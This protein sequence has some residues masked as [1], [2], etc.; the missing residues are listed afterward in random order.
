[1]IRYIFSFPTF[2][3]LASDYE[4]DFISCKTNFNHERKGVF[5]IKPKELDKWIPLECNDGTSDNNNFRFINSRALKTIDLVGEGTRLIDMDTYSIEGKS[6]QFSVLCEYYQTIRLDYFENK[7]VDFEGQIVNVSFSMGI[8]IPQGELDNIHSF[9]L[10]AFFCN[11]DR[12]DRLTVLSKKILRCYGHSKCIFFYH[13]DMYFHSEN[14]L[15]S[16]LNLDDIRDKHIQAGNQELDLKLDEDIFLVF[17]VS[18]KDIPKLMNKFINRDGYVSLEFFGTEIPLEISYNITSNIFDLVNGGATG[19]DYQ[20]DVE[21]NIKTLSNIKPETQIDVFYTPF[22]NETI[23]Y[24][25]IFLDKVYSDIQTHQTKKQFSLSDATKRYLKKEQ[26]PAGTYFDFVHFKNPEWIRD[27]FKRGKVSGFSKT[28][29]TK[30]NLPIPLIL[31]K[32]TVYFKNMVNELF[33]VSLSIDLDIRNM[34]YYKKPLFILSSWII[35]NDR[36]NIQHSIT[37]FNII[38]PEIIVVCN[39]YNNPE[40]INLIK[41]RNIEIT[42]RITDIYPDLNNHNTINNFSITNLIPN[43]NCCEKLGDEK[44]YL[45]NSKFQGATSIFAKPTGSMMLSRCT[46][47]KWAELIN[48]LDPCYF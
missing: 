28:I 32:D 27:N 19:K 34:V 16:I 39:K 5:R 40:N 37:N 48:L 3:P 46:L 6:L 12:Q 18:N 35:V 36:D 47:N 13:D 42:C 14:L 25:N 31:L 29:D 20:L 17:V 7:I 1:M 43:I 10:Q 15:D 41:N 21:V 26:H 38:D 8:S 22:Y 30:I 44:V 4:G 11:E 24:D 45:L 9:K 2:T 33:L 23:K